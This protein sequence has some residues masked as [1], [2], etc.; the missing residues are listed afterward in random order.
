MS[1]KPIRTIAVIGAGVMGRGIALV[2]AKAGF[3]TRV[4][5]PNA[6]AAASARVEIEKIIKRARE[7]GD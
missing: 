6:S 2:A 1:F 7:K 4:V 5:E 3:D